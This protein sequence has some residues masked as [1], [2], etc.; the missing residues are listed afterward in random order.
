MSGFINSYKNIYK[1]TLDEIDTLLQTLEVND[2]E[3]KQVDSTKSIALEKLT[4]IHKK[5]EN[6]IISLESNSEWD[7]FSIAFY[8]ET[9]AGKSTLIE[10]LRILLNEKTKVKER[11]LYEE[12]IIRLNKYKEDILINKNEISSFELKRHQFID[13]YNESL[14][15]Y[16]LQKDALETD[17][18]SLELQICVLNEKII[19]RTTNNLKDFFKY[20]FNNLE[21]QEQINLYNN[22]KIKD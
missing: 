14:K 19:N 13:K 12:S 6:D 18:I 20:I 1:K 7:V 8:G 21:E 10:T 3:D 17:Y 4:S 16:E 9:N 15:E 22:Q 2:F 11:E 5:L